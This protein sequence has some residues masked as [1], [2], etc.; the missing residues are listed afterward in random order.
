MS[1]ICFLFFLKLISETS[2]S[3]SHILDIVKLCEGQ[4]KKRSKVSVKEH[5][6]NVSFHV[7]EMS[8]NMMEFA[9]NSSDWF[10]FGDTI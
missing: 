4:K 9:L 8:C 7:M 6:K 5:N 2:W 3:Y 1:Y 10:N